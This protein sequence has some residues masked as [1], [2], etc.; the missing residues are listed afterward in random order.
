MFS[1]QSRKMWAA[2]KGLVIEPQMMR[3][4]LS[5]QMPNTI[6]AGQ[7]STMS[8]G[9]SARLQSE[10]QR[11][12]SHEPLGMTNIAAEHWQPASVGIPS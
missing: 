6:S 10:K 3:S 7:P 12:A 1:L 9:A 2:G 8:V 4:P 5:S 11:D